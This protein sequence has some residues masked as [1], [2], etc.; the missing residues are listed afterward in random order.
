MLQGLDPVRRAFA[1]SR[2]RPLSIHPPFYR[3]P[4]WPRQPARATARLGALARRL[5]AE[6]FVVHTAAFAERG[7]PNEDRFAQAVERGQLAGGPHVVVGVETA[8]YNK[9]PRQPFALDQLTELVAFCRQHDCGITFDTCHAGA[10]GEDLLASYET[11]R[12]LLR[13]VHLSDVQ[14]RRGQPHTHRLPG[15]GW[16]PL[17]QLL[18]RMAED[19]Y[20]GLV[21]LEVHPLTAG[22][23]SRENAVRRLGQALDFIRSSA[24]GEPPSA[25]APGTISA[26]GGPHR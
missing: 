23:F 20:N 2:V 21:T 9:R 19:G 4:G 7:S 24:H 1:S 26:G 8:Q 25:R 14:W 6:L 11:V 15:E 18:R 3:L 22:P 13:N 10:N 5:G 17:D 12:P 16:L